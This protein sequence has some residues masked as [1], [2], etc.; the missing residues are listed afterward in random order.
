MLPVKFRRIVFAAAISGLVAG[1]I[2]SALQSFGAIPLILKAE[3]YEK[4]EEMTKAGQTPRDEEEG[5]FSRTALTVISNVLTSVGFALLLIA[6]FTIHGD[7]DWRKGILW[8]LGGFATF[9][10]APSI[11]LS[12]ELPGSL[13]APLQERQMWWVATVAGTGGGLI[14]LLFKAG[15]HWKGLGVLLIALPHI[16]GA[17]LPEE[18]GGLA[19][20]QLSRSF[21]MVTFATS[22]I[23][24]LILGGIAGLFSK[25]FEG[26]EGRA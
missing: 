7:V 11:G 3:T 5:G 8:G 1:L 23:Y 15:A 19:P 21:V 14:L 10:L 2:L 6:A 22:A 18:H 17:P 26:V 4:Q 24:W 12:P 25:R 9:F 16:V 20:E 13:A